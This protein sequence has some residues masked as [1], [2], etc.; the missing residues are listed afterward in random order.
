MIALRSLL[1]AVSCCLAPALTAQTPPTAAG[2]DGLSAQ[3]ILDAMGQAY[4]ACSSYRD[5]GTVET[6]FMDSDGTRVETKTFST[7][8]V[9]PDL[10]RFEYRAGSG[11]FAT[12]FIVWRSA[13]DV[14]TWWT[15]QG[16]QT[17]KPLS[18]ALAGATGVSSGSAHTVPVLLMPVEVTG[19]SL[20]TIL[21]DLK[22]LEDA[23][24]GG[25]P[26]YGV[27]GT[28]GPSR[29]A[30][31]IDRRTHLL[32]EINTE[33][34][35]PDFRTVQ[36]TSYEPFSDVEIDEEALAYAAPGPGAVRKPGIPLGAPEIDLSAKPLSAPF[37]FDWQLRSLDG[38]TVDP[39]TLRGKVVFLNSWATWCPPCVAELPS[40]A[41]LRDKVGVRLGDRA[42]EVRFLCISSEPARTLQNFRSVGELDLPAYVLEGRM[43]ALFETDAIPAT[44]IL[45][46]QGRVVLKHIGAAR[47]DDPG[48]V[49]FLVS[50]SEGGDG[51]A[52]SAQPEARTE[53]PGP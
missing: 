19:A 22:R 29:T 3:A 17:G 52:T 31:W 36:V 27:R 4:A 1:V 25:V 30:V 8:F 21:R 44:F 38:T 46:R 2:D 45:D 37:D 9:R 43:P 23:D 16:E 49:D 40:I 42:G 24:V 20:T 39:A 14:R 10:F 33:T 5:T 34:K 53:P 26:C 11:A 18:R 12:R 15:L 32:R 6:T 28:F 41:S 51:E 7:V 47:W 48:C 13:D 50:L 35:F